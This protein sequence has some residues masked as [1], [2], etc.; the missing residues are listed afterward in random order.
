MIRVPRLALCEV[1]QKSTKVECM[2]R[3]EHRRQI[4]GKY[5][6]HGPHDSKP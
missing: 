6:C 3:I 4:A 2:A 5:H 1:C